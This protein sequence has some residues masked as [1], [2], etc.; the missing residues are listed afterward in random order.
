[1]K[2]GQYWVQQLKEQNQSRTEILKDIDYKVLI[3]FP[4][5]FVFV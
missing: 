1:M 5:I 3:L 2:D 4:M